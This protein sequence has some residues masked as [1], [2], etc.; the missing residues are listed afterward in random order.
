[1][2]RI[3]KP[4]LLLAAP[5]D[6]ILGALG[7]IDASGRRGEREVTHDDGPSSMEGTDRPLGREIDLEAAGLQ[8][9]EGGAKN[10]GP[11]VGSREVG[12]RNE[13]RAGDAE[14]G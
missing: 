14:P 12:P 10:S 5:T 3:A 11:V 1:M 2:P 7:G 13:A 4:S 9:R 6:D 8:E